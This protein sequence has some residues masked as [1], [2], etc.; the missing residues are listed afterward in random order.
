MTRSNLRL[1]V[2]REAM[3]KA[4]AGYYVGGAH[5]SVEWAW[6]MCWAWGVTG[7]PSHFFLCYLVERYEARIT[8]GTKRA[9]NL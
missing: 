5:P 8:G 2:L 1:T 4:Q 3:M 9:H 7:I 6:A